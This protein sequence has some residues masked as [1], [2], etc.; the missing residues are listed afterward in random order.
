MFFKKKYDTISVSQLN[1]LLKEN[2]NLIDVREVSEFRAVRIKGAKNVPLMGLISNPTQFLKKDQKYYIVCQSGS[3]S[4]RACSIL[5][6]EGYNVVN[7]SGGTGAFAYQH[8]ENI[9]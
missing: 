7:V 2:I 8:R 4:A 3:R 9:V 1:D 6:Q 5:E